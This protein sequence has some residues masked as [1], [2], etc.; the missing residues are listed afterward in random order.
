MT[1]SVIYS[2]IFSSKFRFKDIT[3]LIQGAPLPMTEA[4]EIIMKLEL[5]ILV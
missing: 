3:F 1:F 4:T 5:P 2:F